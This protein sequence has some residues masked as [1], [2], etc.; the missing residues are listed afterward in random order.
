MQ[1][2]S[3]AALRPRMRESAGATWLVITSLGKWRAFQEAGCWAFHL[4]SMKRAAKIAPGDLG[5][6]YLTQERNLPAGR[7]VALIEFCQ[8]GRLMSA[9]PPFESFYPFLV[10]FRLVQSRDSLVLFS[11]LVPQLSFIL[12]KDRYGPYLQGKSAIR[13][14]SNDARLLVGAVRANRKI[15][16]IPK[17]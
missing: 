4:Y 16:R 7:L 2:Q 17:R 10:P 13:L 9:G 12:R 11:T 15:R 14:S 8:K 1:S 5:V 3:E 6:V